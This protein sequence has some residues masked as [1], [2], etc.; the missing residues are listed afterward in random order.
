MENE[1]QDLGTTENRLKDTKHF[2]RRKLR[3][4]IYT[5]IALI[6]LFYTLALIYSAWIKS[7][8]ITRQEAIRRVEI[9]NDIPQWEVLIVKK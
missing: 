8:A 2:E 7:Q 3:S 6:V 4:K 5:F 9:A 1:I